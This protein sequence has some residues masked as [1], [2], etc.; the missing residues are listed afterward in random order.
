M[1]IGF[2]QKV[3]VILVLFAL[4]AAG[5]AANGDEEGASGKTYSLK[6]AHIQPVDHP[7]GQAAERFAEIV[8]EKTN[9]R[10]EIQVFPAAQ[11]GNEKDIFD[12]V[13]IGVTDFA[14]LGYGE[15][16]KR[17]S[18]A[19][20]FDA[21]FLAENRDHLVRIFNS[22][23]VQEIFDDMETE[24][25]VK[26]IAP[27]YY[28]S[29]FLTTSNKPVRTPADLAGMK[30]RVP[31]QELYVET[32]RSM[33]ATPV[34][35]AF[36]EVYLALQQGIIDGQENPPA[37]IATNKFY[38]VQDYISTTGHIMGGNCFYVSSRTMEE[39]PEDLQTAIVETGKEIAEWTNEA[40][41]AAEDKYLQVIADN[42]VTVIDDPDK[43]AF[44]DRAQDLHNAYESRWGEG[45]M[46]KIRAVK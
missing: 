19:L 23:V 38:E 14:V 2:P 8:S 36:P 1:K 10:V 16:A 9:G 4:V 44:I 3:F 45:L 32:L 30:I 33:G 5:L 7:N 20:I 27:F 39:L 24:I 42:G 31:D 17:F 13:V 12:S 18:P 21:P 46:A 43:A 34:P 15:P 6:L 28:G 26:A 35:I 11:L 25:G 29:R 40:A 22:D 37:T 41:F